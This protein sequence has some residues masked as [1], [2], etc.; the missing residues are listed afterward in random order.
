MACG[1][2]KSGST[3]MA[4]V[5][6]TKPKGKASAPASGKMAGVVTGKPK[7]KRA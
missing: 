6:S 1:K 7:T 5:V 3:K 4:G 2:A